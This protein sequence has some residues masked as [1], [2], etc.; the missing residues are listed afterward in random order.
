MLLVEPVI[1]WF[2][3]INHAHDDSQHFQKQ[4]EGRGNPDLLLG[5]ATS[6]SCY[7]AMQKTAWYRTD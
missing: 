1:K 2:C 7:A 3:A 6:A 4:Q 5:K